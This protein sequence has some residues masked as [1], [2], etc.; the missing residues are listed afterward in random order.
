MT[1]K[2]RIK[3][4]LDFKTPDRIGMHDAFLDS[5]IKDWG[6]EG[7]PKGISL[8]R[9]FDF[10]I[11]IIDI[12][13]ALS[14]PS[15]KYKDDQKFLCL[16]FSEPFQALC[17]L[18]GRE[19]TLKRLLLYPKDMEERLKVE[20]DKILNSLNGI[21]GKKDSSFNG[22]WVW[23]D[24]AYNGGPVFSLSFYKKT[25]LP[26]HK[27]IFAS[28]HSCGLPIFFHSDGNIRDLIPHLLDSGV[29]AIHPLE[30]ASGMDISKL[31][32]D[33]KRRLVFMGYFNIVNM[34]KDKNLFKDRIRMLKE[35]C[36]YIYQADYPIMQD[37]SFKDYM[38][39]IEMI[40]KAGRYC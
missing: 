34:L 17:G 39:A 25:L 26:L 6:N 9:Y 23:G 11:E 1:S 36:S 19:E 31:F 37:T 8:E 40:R 2:E 32:R 10:D 28:L 27:E 33:Y 29:R 3:R 21:I 24:L 18:F 5:T 4:T 22:A 38:L 12:H 35:N 16:S 7:L 20:T 30:E 14:K 13:E 15:S